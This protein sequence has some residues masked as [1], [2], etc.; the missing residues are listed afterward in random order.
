M[1]FKEVI[2]EEDVDLSLELLALTM[3]QRYAAQ[4]QLGNRNFLS[5]S[6]L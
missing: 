6:D 2:H 1:R 5:S 4:S 3:L